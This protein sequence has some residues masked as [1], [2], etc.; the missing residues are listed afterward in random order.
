VIG[1]ART[2]ATP[3]A[4]MLAQVASQARMLLGR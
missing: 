4:A 2:A 3:T 1:R